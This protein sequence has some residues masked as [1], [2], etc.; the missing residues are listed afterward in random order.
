[1][2]LCGVFTVFTFL[3]PVPDWIAQNMKSAAIYP[4]IKWTLKSNTQTEVIKMAKKNEYELVVYNTHDPERFTV[5]HCD[6]MT[7]SRD[8]YEIVTASCGDGPYL[9]FYMDAEADVIYRLRGPYHGRETFYI[10]DST[11]LLFENNTM[12]ASLEKTH[13]EVRESIILKINEIQSRGK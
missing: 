9:A 4:K 2:I 3:N 1:M 7:I 12:Y 10:V 5:L 13:M 6:G 8:K 11:V